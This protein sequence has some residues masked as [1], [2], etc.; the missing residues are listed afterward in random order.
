MFNSSIWTRQI[1]RATWR[2]DLAYGWCN[3]DTGCAGRFNRS[4]QLCN[5]HAC[6]LKPVELFICGDILSTQLI[7]PG[8]VIW[9]HYIIVLESV[10]QSHTHTHTHSCSYTVINLSTALLH[11][12]RYC[13]F[14]VY[15]QVALLSQRGRAMLRVYN[16]SGASSASDLRL[17][18]IK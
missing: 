18:T 10:H 9:A 5:E 1:M 13:T 8:C 14:S 7:E 12:I 16:T 2:L 17:R 15:Q 11:T 3:A 6:L 4:M